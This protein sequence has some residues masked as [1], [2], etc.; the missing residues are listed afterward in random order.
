[1]HTEIDWTLG[2]LDRL[3]YTP[4]AHRMHHSRERAEADMNY[5]GFFTVFDRLFG[6]WIQT[7][8][9]DRPDAYGL[10]D[11]EPEGIREVAFGPMMRFWRGLRAADGLLAK[12]RYALTR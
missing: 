10:P 4:S 8:R 9:T 1:M 12:L 6:T 5:G 2:P 7:Q 3:V 11:W